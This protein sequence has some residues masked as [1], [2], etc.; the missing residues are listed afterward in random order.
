MDNSWLYSYDWVFLTY[1]ISW[2]LLFEDKRKARQATRATWQINKH[3]WPIRGSEWRGEVRPSSRVKAPDWWR[4][5]RQGL[6]THPPYLTNART[7]QPSWSKRTSERRNER[8]CGR[9][10]MD[11][12]KSAISKNAEKRKKQRLRF[13]SFF[14]KWKIRDKLDSGIEQKNLHYL[15]IWLLGNVLCKTQ[16]KLMI[17]LLI[18]FDMLLGLLNDILWY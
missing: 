7:A 4:D 13:S 6:L 8:T 2:L 10:P 17:T 1:S 5:R 9:N 12:E 18:C 3:S 16:R 15:L 11:P 14:R